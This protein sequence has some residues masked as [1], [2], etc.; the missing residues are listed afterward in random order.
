[1]IE[2]TKS[3]LIYIPAAIT[4]NPITIIPKPSDKII[5][6]TPTKRGKRTMVIKKTIILIM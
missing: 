5:V 3:T 4:N 2:I 1:M 6:I